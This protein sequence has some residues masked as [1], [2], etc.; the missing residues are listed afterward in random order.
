MDHD[1][2]DALQPHLSHRLGQQCWRL[3]QRKANDGG[4][5]V[6]N[7]HK[8]IFSLDAQPLDIRI[9]VTQKRLI[10]ANSTPLELFV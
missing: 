9:V 6:G 3:S 4:V 1:A 2:A 8:M 7:L 10:R 5:F